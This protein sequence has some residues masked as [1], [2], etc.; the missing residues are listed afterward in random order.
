MKSLVEEMAGDTLLGIDFGGRELSGGQ[1]QQI[2]LLRGYYKPSELLVMDE[3]TSSLDPLK[4]LE[5]QKRLLHIL[6]GKTGVI[7]THRLSTAVLADRIIVM[8]NGRVEECGTKEELLKKKGVFR[9]MWDAQL[10]LFEERL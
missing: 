1:W 3:P 10:S 8:N 4:E 5:L 7:V 9:R 6:T 2:A